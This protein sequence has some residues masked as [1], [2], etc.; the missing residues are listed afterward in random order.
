[1]PMPSY[2]EVTQRAGSLRAMTGLTDTEFQALLPYFEQAFETYMG[3]HTIDELCET[4]SDPG[5]PGAAVWD[6]PIECQQVDSPVARR[7]EPDISRPRPPSSPDSRGVGR[8]AHEAQDRS[9]VDT[10]PCW[11]DGTER[12]IQRPKDPEEQEEYYSGKKKHHTLKNLLVINER[13]HMAFLSHTYEGK[14]SEKGI[15]ELAG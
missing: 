10:S 3:T 13:C 4:P 7:V 12:P 2:E 15:A 1:M 14:A 11:H 5:T 6:V 8:A 9:D